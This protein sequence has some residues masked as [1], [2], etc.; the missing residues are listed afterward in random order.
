MTELFTN[1][2]LSRGAGM[3]IN[4]ASPTIQNCTF[5][6]N[7]SEKYGGGIACEAVTSLQILDTDFIGNF[8]AFSGGGADLDNS[9]VEIVSCEFDGNISEFFGGGGVSLFQGVAFIY[10]C[11]IQNNTAATDGGGILHLDASETIIS[12]TK[13]QE[14]TSGF[15]GG[16]VSL[17]YTSRADLENCLVT[18]NSAGWQ[19]GGLGCDQNS[20]SNIK[21]ATFTMN[22]AEDGGAIF[23]EDSNINI[24]NSILWDDTPREIRNST[25]SLDISYSDIYLPMSLV[26]PG[27]GNINGA[28]F[29]TSGVEG[30][31]YLSQFA[32]GE[33]QDSPCIDQGSGPAGSVC[34]SIPTGGPVCM[35]EMTTRSDEVKDT[36]TVDMGFHF[37]S[38]LKNKISQWHSNSHI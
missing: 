36:G 14:N 22:T 7:D 32:S 8:A 27:V 5:N 19:G 17:R 10:D 33:P 35:D 30:A 38:S 21:N 24:V 11:E 26:W 18:G 23:C 29:F 28:P 3:Y 2:S 12:F 6:G 25:G 16:G 13:I 31:F 4:S 37:I 20:T 15:D 34:F 9:N 1:T